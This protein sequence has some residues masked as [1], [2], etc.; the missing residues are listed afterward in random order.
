MTDTAFD[1][2]VY[3]APAPPVDDPVLYGVELAVAR[4][5]A[6]VGLIGV[7]TVGAGVASVGWL[8]GRRL[9]RSIRGAI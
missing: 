3:D 4:A 7:L 9:V 6:I 1:W 8:V 5:V 2:S